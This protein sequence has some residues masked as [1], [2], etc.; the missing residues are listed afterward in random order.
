M[1][2]NR[3]FVTTLVLV[4]VIAF[5]FAGGYLFGHS[6]VLQDDNI[7]TSNSSSREAI[8]EVWDIIFADYVDQSSLDSANISQAAIEGMLEALD[9]PYTSYLDEENYILGQSSLE[10]SYQGIGAYVTVK[11]KQITIIAPIADSPAAKAGIKAGDVVLEIGGVS[12]ADMS[13]AEAIIK[14]RGPIG[15]TV[16]LLVLHKGDTEPVEIEITRASF[17]I[18]SLRFEMKG[19]M[20]YINITDFTERTPNELATALQSL[21]DEKA[22]GIVLDLRGNPGGLLDPVVDVASS[23][24]SEGIVVQVRSNKGEITQLS[25]KTDKP[26]TD[27]S[28]V[29][30]VDKASASG[31]E[32]LAG[33]LQDH[34]RATIAGTTTY[35]KG[36]VDALYPLSD[37]SGLYLTIARWLT[38]N[39]RLIEGQ[40]IEPDITLDVTGDEEIQWAIDYLTAHGG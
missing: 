12:T 15:T 34:K 7:P 33:A 17:D 16:R 8:G 1:L 14:I 4:I 9:D 3:Q 39:G 36:S 18:P 22:K 30:L 28:M 13:L 35:G 2:K 37:G 11:D 23:F 38:P 6:R 29:V 32:V 31:S 21:A 19:E 27:L 26:R 25:V 24:L 40:G 10:G 20:A 5:A